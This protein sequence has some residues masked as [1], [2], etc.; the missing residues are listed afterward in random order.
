[1]DPRPRVVAA[2]LSLL[3][4][5]RRLISALA[6]HRLPDLAER[7]SI[8]AFFPHSVWKGSGRASVSNNKSRPLFLPGRRSLSRSYSSSKVGSH[9]TTCGRRAGPGMV[10]NKSL[11]MRACG[12]SSES[13][14][15]LMDMVGHV[16]R[17]GY[18]GRTQQSINVYLAMPVIQSNVHP[19]MAVSVI[20]ET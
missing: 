18:H 5:L 8:H 15:A 11:L 4:R 14:C 12:R 3:L 20:S 17:G 7:P 1:M 19:T 16:R 6:R 9:R 13:K 2:L 10:F